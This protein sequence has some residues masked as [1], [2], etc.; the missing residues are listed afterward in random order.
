ML[1]L[2]YPLNFKLQYLRYELNVMIC[3]DIMIEQWKK[4]FKQDQFMKIYAFL[5]EKSYYIL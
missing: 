4:N 1:C 2:N 3:R 5:I